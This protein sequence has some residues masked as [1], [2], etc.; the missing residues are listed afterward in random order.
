MLTM[1]SLRAM[2]A[3][4]VVSAREVD[5]TV[6]VHLECAEESPGSAEQDAG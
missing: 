6:A 4:V 5:Q 2:G 3:G 1:Q